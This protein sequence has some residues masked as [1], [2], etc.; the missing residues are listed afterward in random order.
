MVNV[1]GLNAYTGQKPSY[2]FFAQNACSDGS[3]G[4]MATASQECSS[5]GRAS[6]SKTEGPRFESVHS[7]HFS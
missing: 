6:V 7:C 3:A 1:G 4:L 2:E 5:V